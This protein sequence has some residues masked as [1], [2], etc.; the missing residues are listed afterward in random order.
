MRLCGAEFAAGRHEILEW[1]RVGKVAVVQ[2]NPTRSGGFTEMMRIAELCALEGVQVIPHGWNHGIGAQAAYHFQAAAPNVPYV[3][4]RTHRLFPSDL[5]RDL[6]H[7]AEQPVADGRS[8]LPDGPGLGVTLDDE[9]V[10][11]YRVA[12]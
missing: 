12:P 5:R 10:R 8:P 9:V 11:R 1:I 6:V 2:P 3:E 7:P 4:Y